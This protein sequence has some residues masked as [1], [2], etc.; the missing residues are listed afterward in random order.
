MQNMGAINHDQ[1]SFEL[2]INKMNYTRYQKKQ[3]GERK[4]WEE[5]PHLC[6]AASLQPQLD[7]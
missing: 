1:K 6:L 4:Q 2:Q 3:R 7:S 5:T